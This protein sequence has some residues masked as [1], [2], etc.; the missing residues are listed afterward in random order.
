MFGKRSGV[1]VTVILL[2][3]LAAAASGCSAAQQSAAPVEA[4]LSATVEEIRT[5]QAQGWGVRIPGLT[6]AAITDDADSAVISEVVSGSERPPEQ[7]LLVQADRFHVGSATKSFT[8]ALIMQ[9]DQES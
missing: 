8:A 4:A 2:T 3:A 5:N 7:V 9:L 1:R 6:A